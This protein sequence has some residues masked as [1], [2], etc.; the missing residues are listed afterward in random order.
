MKRSLLI[1]IL[2][3]GFSLSTSA[4]V[5]QWAS[6]VIEFSSELTPVQYSAQQALGKPNVLPAGGQSP[7]A[8]AP[9]RPKRAEFLKLGFANPISIRQ[10]AIA[11]SHNPS[12]ISRVLAYDEAG[13]E[14]VIN[15]LNPMP[16]PLKGRM[17]NLFVEMTSFKVAA[18]KIEFDGAAVP[19]Y[20]GIDAVAISD[21]NYPIIADIPK[22]QLLASGIA[23]ESLDKNVNSDYS[24]LSPVL[25]PDGKTLYFSR[26][27]HPENVGGVDDKEDIWYSELD[28]TGRW[29]LAKNMGPQFNNAG[30]NFVNSIQ[31]VTP[32]GKSAVMVLGNRYLENGK[33]AAG[34]SIS[35]NVG[36]QWSKPVALNIKNDY[37]YAEKAHYFLANNR[38]TLLMSVEREDTHGDRDLYVSFMNDDSTWTEPLNLGDVLNSAAE[39]SAPFLASDDKTLYFSSKGFS[40]YGGSDVY[41]SRRLD[42]TWTNWSEPENLGP[43]INSPLEDLF[44]NIPVSSDFAYYSRGVTETNTDIFRVKLPIVKNPEP[45]VTVKGKI[46]DKATGKP[47]GAK[48]VYERLPDGKDVGI[49]QSNPETGEYEIRLPAGQLYGVR[50]EA[51]GKISESQSLDLRDVKTDKVIEHSDFS[52]SPIE[53]ADAKENVVIVMNNVF[54]EFDKATLKAESYPELDRIV[55]FLKSK[56][57]I[58]IEISGHTDAVGEESY[59]LG[60]SQRRANSVRQYLT[61][62]GVP[63]ERIKA[64]YFGETRPVDSN[65]TKEGRRK[66]RRVEFKIL[67]M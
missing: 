48:I 14:Y 37:N 7:N 26:Q 8:W 23:I 30:P 17:L 19:D 56:E 42:D 33:M 22:M 21:S 49:A 11:E 41:V 31:A 13:K 52:L 18:I 46:I 50:A 9:D 65:E 57:T 40:G 43:E 25:S 53:V 10:I 62:K 54:F 64:V 59:N 47:L 61:G 3:A 67:K 20:F 58:E 63:S 5:V 12:A 44:F 29:Q 28:S 38:K 66:N 51:A 2:L 32:D 6:K 27:N 39:E 55:D 60:L 24:E 36:G 1:T 4:Q 34:V 45:W 16:V 15:T 35:S